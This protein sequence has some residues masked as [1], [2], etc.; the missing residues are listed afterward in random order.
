MSPF[1]S[2]LLVGGFAL[3]VAAVTVRAIR[4]DRRPTGPDPEPA[5]VAF[6][7]DSHGLWMWDTD[8]NAALIVPRVQGMHLV[9]VGHLFRALDQFAETTAG[10][11]PDCGPLIDELIRL[12]GEVRV[13]REELDRE[14]AS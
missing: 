2:W 3:A 10:P 5:G 7:V 1:W 4:R 8:S 12:S 13:M 6:E 14:R 11:V 9:D